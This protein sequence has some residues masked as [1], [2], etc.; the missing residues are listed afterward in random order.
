MKKP[1]YMKSYELYKQSLASKIAE[2]S[3]TVIEFPESRRWDC[4]IPENYLNFQDGFLWQVVSYRCM[5][6]MV[7]NGEIIYLHRSVYVPELSECLLCF[8]RAGRK[9]C[10]KITAEGMSKYPEGNPSYWEF[11]KRVKPYTPSRRDLY[12]RRHNNVY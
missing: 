9:Y 1:D 11:I 10:V 6:I 12:N 8:D 7:Y 3:E 5:P 4:A 2:Y